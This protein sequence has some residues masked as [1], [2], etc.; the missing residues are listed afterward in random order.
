M[1]KSNRD[2]PTEI[3]IKVR[4]C[5]KGCVLTTKGDWKNKQCWSCNQYVRF[6]RHPN[7]EVRVNGVLFEKGKQWY[8]V[9]ESEIEED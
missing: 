4:C 6:K 8:V 9:A 7:M 2:K 3:T 1:P 5:Q